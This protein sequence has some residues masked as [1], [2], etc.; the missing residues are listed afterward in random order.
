MKKKLEAYLL[1][2]M[3]KKMRLNGLWIG[4]CFIL[5]ALNCL[6]IMMEMNGSLVTTDLKLNDT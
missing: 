6:D 1:N 5:H 4:D 2:F 3:E